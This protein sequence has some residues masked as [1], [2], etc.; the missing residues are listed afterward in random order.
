MKKTLILI[1]MTF[2][3][4]AGY[5]MVFATEYV[6]KEHSITVA[7]GDTLWSIAGRYVE[8]GEDVRD[9]IDRISAANDLKSRVIY[10]GQVLRVP[11]RVEAQDAMV[12][13]K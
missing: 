11:V 5:N 8:R 10:A 7:N 4:F 13:K 2:T 9:V 3:L 6:Y 1:C 12:A